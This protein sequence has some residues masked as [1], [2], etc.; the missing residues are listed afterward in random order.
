MAGQKQQIA[1]RTTGAVPIGLKKKAGRP[2]T[3][4]KTSRKT[5]GTPKASRRKGGA[6]QGWCLPPK[7]KAES[8]ILLQQALIPNA[9][10]CPVTDEDATRKARRYR[11]GTVALREIRRYQRSTDLLLLKLPFSRLVS[12]SYRCPCNL[13]IDAEVGSRDRSL[14]PP[15]RRPLP[16]LAKPSHTSAAGS[17]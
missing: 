16:A 12:S 1:R 15:R 4:G 2:S 9:L 5:I 6:A 7:I 17:R 8:T 11:P 14:P 3:G 10:T 13:P